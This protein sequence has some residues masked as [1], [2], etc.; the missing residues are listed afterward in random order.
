MGHGRPLA[1]YVVHLI[2]A[3][4]EWADQAEGRSSNDVGTFSAEAQ[5]RLLLDDHSQS[6][7]CDAMDIDSVD[8]AYSRHPAHTVRTYSRQLD[9]DE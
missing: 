2:V 7:G 1:A 4:L 6:N 8:M 3:Q 5:S 9:G